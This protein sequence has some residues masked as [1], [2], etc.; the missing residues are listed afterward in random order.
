MDKLKTAMATAPIFVF[1]DWKKEFHV[2]F[3]VLS[4]VL[5]IVLT[6][7]GEG[8]LDHP[9]AFESRKLSTTEKKL[10]DDRKR[11]P[12]YG[13]CASKIPTLFVGWTFSDVH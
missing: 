12:C 9:I 11:R 13:L 3:D 2:H 4:T 6:Q 8:A 1:P 7:P 5:G 10:H